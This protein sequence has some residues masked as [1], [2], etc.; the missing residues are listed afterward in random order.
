MAPVP[1]FR[2]VIVA[3]GMTEPL[4]SDT[5]PR[6]LPIAPCAAGCESAN[7]TRSVVHTTNESTKRR[8]RIPTMWISSLGAYAY[9]VQF[10]LKIGPDSARNIYPG[11]EA[12]QGAHGSQ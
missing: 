2:A 4:E 1:V 10:R 5:V 8:F 7:A 3:P 9:V 6:M 11:V 12:S